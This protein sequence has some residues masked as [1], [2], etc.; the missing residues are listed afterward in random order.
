MNNEEYKKKCMDSY[1]KHLEEIRLI[2]REFVDANNPHKVGDMVTDHIG[3]IK[4]E[5]IGYSYS[6]RFWDKGELPYALY[7]GT[8]YTKKGIPSKKGEKRTVHQCNLIK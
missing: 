2:S 3:T 7:L 4:I 5:E 8:V 1:Q 6:S